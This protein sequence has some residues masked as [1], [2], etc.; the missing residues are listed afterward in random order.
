MSLGLRILISG[1]I[2]LTPYLWSKEYKVGYINSDQIITK[3]EVA[4]AAKKELTAEIAK[5]EATAESL[6]AEYEQAKDE[7]ESQQLSLSE[8]G[9]RTKLAEVEARKQRYE[10]YLKEVYGKNGKI[11]QKNQELIAPI[12]AQIDSAVRKVATEEGFSLVIDAAKAGVVYADIGLDL[13]SLVIEE[14]NRRYAPTPIIAPTKPLYAILPI[15]EEN[16][17]AQQ[18]RTGSSIRS[19]IN[20]ALSKAK[21]RLELIPDR[22]VDEVVQT[23]GYLGSLIKSEQALEVA[24]ALDVDYCIFGKC[25]KRERQVQF[26]L[27]LIDVRQGTLVQSQEGESPKPELLR[28]RVTAVVQTLYQS[29]ER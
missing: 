7:Y 2:F 1:F 11:E 4:I 5:Y 17:E 6:K 3:Y 9:K 18:A 26:E 24:R 28:E 19:Y 23:R 12:V 15:Y 13:T 21:P 29:L 16:D 25:S 8:E 14:L 20:S 10:N 27:S 22:K